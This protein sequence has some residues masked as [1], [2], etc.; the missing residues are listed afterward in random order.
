MMNPSVKD[1]EDVHEGQIIRVSNYY[2]R[3]IEFYIDRNTWLPLRQMIYD[4]KGLYERY[5]VKN[6]I[7]NPVF[8]AD[9]FSRENK[10]YKF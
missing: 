9:E 8:K 1:Y 3:K 7:W 6:F 4:Q 5:E 10:E 2:N